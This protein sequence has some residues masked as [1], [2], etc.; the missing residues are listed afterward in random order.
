LKNPD[1]RTIF[2]FD[3]L[4][5]ELKRMRTNIRRIAV[6]VVVHPNAEDCVSTT[7]TPGIVETDI[8][9]DRAPCTLSKKPPDLFA[10][11]RAY[12]FGIGGRK[13]AKDFSPTER[14]KSRFTHSRRK[15]L[16]T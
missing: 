1:G 5:T 16:A 15:N 12:E 10:L 7:L 3:G 6:C 11:W 13:A 8:L 9:Q 14:G 4:L 2:N